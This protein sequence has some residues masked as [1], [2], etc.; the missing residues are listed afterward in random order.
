MS[1]SK[2]VNFV[3]CKIADLSTKYIT[4]QDGELIGRKDAPGH[5]ASI[6]GWEGNQD[7]PGDIFWVGQ[8]EKEHKEQDAYLKNFGFSKAFRHI[9][10][11]L[12][13]QKIP[14]VRFDRDGSEIFG[15]LPEFDW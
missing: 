5:V 8:G 14:Y 6:D 12:A 7:S 9:F 15:N 3:T 4:Q 10:S 13:E 2:K 11:L 1:K